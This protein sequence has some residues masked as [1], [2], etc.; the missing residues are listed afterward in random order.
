MK[1]K[2]LKISTNK[3]F[4]RFAL[5]F[6]ILIF[7]FYI[8]TDKAEAASLYFDPNQKEV[9]LG[10][11]FPVEIR[12][13]A[14]NEDL[15][16]VEIKVGIQDDKLKLIDWSDGGSIINYWA[17]EPR[18][19]EFKNLTFQGG[20]VG[21]FKEKSGKILTLYYE[22]LKPGQS[23]INIQSLSTVYLND[24]KGTKAN[25]KFNNA[26]VN[27]SSEKIEIT[28]FLIIDTTPPE[29]LE[30]I[31]SS[32]KDVYDGKYFVVFAAKDND[33]GLDYIEIK[34]GDEPWVRAESPYL[35]KNQKLDKD[36]LIK[37]VDKNGNTR[38]E[39]LKLKQYQLI[40]KGIYVVV[41][42]LVILAV[43]TIF[44]KRKD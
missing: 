9:K 41:L 11:L 7:A 35:L 20:I 33:S 36:V 16:A 12:L 17:M 24:G 3:R 2:K 26:L 1:N 44:K 13:D 28:E 22:A 23:S 15:N 30:A 32:S 10:E 34:E 25:L 19:D 37:V 42:I 5:S 40:K 8:F 4:L 43:W 29:T 31:I 6:C 21:G 14:E 18:V 27:I 38:I 39:T